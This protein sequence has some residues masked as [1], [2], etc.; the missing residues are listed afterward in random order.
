MDIITTLNFRIKTNERRIETL[1]HSALNGMTPS[2]PFPR[3]QG[4]LHRRQCKESEQ[5]ENGKE[6]FLNIA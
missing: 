3:A 2:S 1:A 5:M 6:D 4:P